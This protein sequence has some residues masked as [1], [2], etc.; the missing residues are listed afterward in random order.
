[1]KRVFPWLII[2]V[3]FFIRIFFYYQSKPFYPEGTKIRITDRVT[4]EPI[5]Y[6]DSRYLK[7]HGF[8][9]YLPLYPEVYY[10]DKVVVEGVVRG[11]KLKEANLVEIKESKSFL[12]KIRKSLIDFYQKNLPQPHASL[13]AGVTIGSKANIGGYFWE[14]LKSSG[15]AHVVV[16]SGMNV[17]L[18]AKFLIAVFVVFF[19]RK[20]AIP[21]AL[22]GVWGY[23]LMSGFDAPIIR[24]AIMGSITFV[25]QEIGRLY[26]AWRA[27]FLSAFG[28]LIVKP[29]WLTDVGFI[30]SFA[31][32]ASLML[33]EAKIRKYLTFVPSLI[34]ED[35]STSLAA[36][37]FIAP[38]LFFTFGRFNI[39]SPLI[40]AVVLWTIVPMTM[41]GMISGLI[42]LISEPIGTLILW[43]EYPLTSWFI[44][45]VEL[46]S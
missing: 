6:R 3:I 10:G 22:I 14:S 13:V 15:T 30:M 7:L 31:A 16:A 40:N 36:Q 28:M 20:K 25:L 45:V 8:K 18:V 37:V 44:N 34:R 23:A 21:L 26:Y 12:H 38:V 5:R 33:F 11:D 2:I 27:L 43:L 46:F 19:P 29:E 1:M 4:S 35:L 41:I 24:A 42:G 9:I 39:L 17:T 32:T